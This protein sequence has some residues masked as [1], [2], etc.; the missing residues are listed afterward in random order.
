MK[1]G[2]TQMMNLLNRVNQ[3]KA[4]EIPENIKLGDMPGDKVAV[5]DYVIGKANVIFQKLMEEL[6]VCSRTQGAERIVVSVCG[7]SGVGKSGIAALLSHYLKEI[8]IQ[9]YTLS[10]DNYPKRIPVYNDAERLSIF[11]QG[12]IRGMIASKVYTNNSKEQL[13]ELQMEGMDADPERCREYS[14]L[15]AYINGGREALKGYLGTSQEQDYDELNRIIS[16]FKSGEECIWL[17]RMG[18]SDTELW[19]DEV[20]FDKTSILIIEWTHANSDYLHG[21]DIPILLSSTPQETMIYRKMRSRDGHA[22]SPFTTMV[23]EIEQDLLDSQAHKAK[24][25]LSKQGELLTY[26]KYLEDM[27]V[28]KE[29]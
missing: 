27:R 23:L 11:R 22:D 8:G 3:W 25:I 14:W 17:K 5:G 28:A 20:T 29:V 9:S 6:V 21:V 15:Q 7:G 24:I 16:E 19:Y 13:H 10:G 2:Q 12:G 4:P 26:K 1:S 18:R